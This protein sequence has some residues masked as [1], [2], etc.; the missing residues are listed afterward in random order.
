MSYSCPQCGA[1]YGTDE[2]CEDRFH[3]GQAR[4]M[5]D[6][7]FLAAHH[8]SVPCFMLQHNRYSRDGWI[9]V[10]QMLTRFLNGLTPAEARRS[11]RKAVDSGNRT[12]SFT[13]GLKLAGVESIPWTRT[14][15]DVRLDTAEHYCTD[16]WE[17]ATQIVRDSED[18][19]RT[20]G[21]EEQE[22][23]TYRQENKQ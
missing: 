16:V 17:W 14:I 15:A 2:T 6:A 21:V 20:V 18:L 9:Q 22:K 23:K 11:A 5:T 4:E 3:A 1:T 12:Y 19:M 13:R 10:R 8:L 7:A